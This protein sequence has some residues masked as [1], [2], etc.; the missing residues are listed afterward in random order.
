MATWELA[1]GVAALTA[2]N[3]PAWRLPVLFLAVVHFG[4]HAINHLADVSEADPGW[5]GPFDLAALSASPVL[6]AW[7]LLR[8][9]RSEPRG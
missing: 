1:L 3:R 9:R 8:A 5:V 6:L 4:L 2:A 7:L